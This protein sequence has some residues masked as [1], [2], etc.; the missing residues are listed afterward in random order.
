MDNP[1]TLGHPLFY[2]FENYP[3]IFS[4]ISELYLIFASEITEKVF[5]TRII[6]TDKQLK[7]MKRFFILLALVLPFGVS[8]A[9][10]DNDRI[11]DK[12]KLP[13][14]AQSFINEHFANA[15]LSYAKLDKDFL[16]SSYEVVF[17]D[18]SRLEFSNKGEWEEVDCRR[19]EVPAV[20]IPAALSEYVKANYPDNKIVRIERDSRGYEL[21][22][23]NGLEL[24][25]NKDFVIV[26]IDD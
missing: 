8:V 10:A 13:A 14:A 24:K 2:I 9:S 21:K 12:S 15:K 20:L 5:V 1:F 11:I 17:A 3:A 4:F 22:L 25:F 23:S 19:N 26:D 6:L 16:I 7:I 18:G